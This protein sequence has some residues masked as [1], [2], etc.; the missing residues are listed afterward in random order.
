MS[1]TNKYEFDEA[2]F[3]KED[4]GDTNSE[5]MQNGLVSDR[6]IENLKFRM[7]PLNEM[8][9]RFNCAVMEIETKFK[10]LNAQFSL[11]Y[12]RNPIESIKSRLKSRTSLVKKL[13]SKNLPFDIEVIEQNINDIAGIRVICSFLE[14]IY[15]LEESFLRQDDIKLIK[16]KDYIKNP[17]PNG[18][19]SLHLIVEV[20]IFLKDET[21]NVRAEVQFRTIAMDFWASLEHKLRYKKNRTEEQRKMIEKELFEC[22]EQSAALDNKMQRLR[23]Y[24]SQS[25]DDE[26]EDQ[27]DFFEAD[28]KLSAIIHGINE[29]N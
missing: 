8:Y 2:A 22:A 29:D 11:E 10:V 7:K 16:R 28:G 25:D 1:D 20:P 13:K 12:D 19:R 27:N 15:A 14:D 18:Y 6:M 17:K 21:R 4:L 5:I 24:L 26:N 9:S 3:N 23:E